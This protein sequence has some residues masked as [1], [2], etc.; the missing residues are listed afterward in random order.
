VTTGY[1]VHMYA[2]IARAADALQRIAVVLERTFPEQRREV[3][4]TP[5]EEDE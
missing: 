4:V 2:D 3:T 1:E 5:M